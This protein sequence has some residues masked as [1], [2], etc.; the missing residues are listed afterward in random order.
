MSKQISNG[1]TVIKI[2]SVP[3]ID[4]LTVGDR[5]SMSP[6]VIA[7]NFLSPSPVGWRLPRRRF[8]SR[9]IASRLRSMIL[10]DRNGHERTWRLRWSGFSHREGR[11]V[12]RIPATAVVAGGFGGGGETETHE[13]CG[14]RF[15]DPTQ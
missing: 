12:V 15:L 11:M 14:F 8:L 10:L 6:T 13:F 2:F 4:T 9:R 5:F 3:E 1:V 7:N